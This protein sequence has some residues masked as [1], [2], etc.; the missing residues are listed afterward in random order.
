MNFLLN[1]LNKKDAMAWFDAFRR[2]TI[3]YSHSIVA[4]GLELIS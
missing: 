4:G 2:S 3:L 1:E